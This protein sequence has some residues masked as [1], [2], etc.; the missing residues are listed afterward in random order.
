M[1]LYP[2]AELRDTEMLK[3]TKKSFA[4]HYFKID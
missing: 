2:E 1:N 4:D 3:T